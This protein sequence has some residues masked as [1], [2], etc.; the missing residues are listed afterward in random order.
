MKTH[1]VTS[2]N[3]APAVCRHGVPLYDYC[4]HCEEGW[5]ATAALEPVRPDHEPHVTP[6]GGWLLIAALVAVTLATVVWAVTR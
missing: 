5:T 6:V 4:P 2:D 3:L 1:T